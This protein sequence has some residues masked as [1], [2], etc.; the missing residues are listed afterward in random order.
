MEKAPIPTPE[1]DEES[2]KR[3]S[4][5]KKLRK[6]TGVIGI[7]AATLGSAEVD[8]QKVEPY[9][10]KDNEDYKRRQ[11]LYDDSL[12]AY[13]ESQKT[14]EMYNSSS[15]RAAM[16]LNGIKYPEEQINKFINLRN[17]ATNKWM[18]TDDPQI[19]KTYKNI[20]DNYQKV[21]NAIG[22]PYEAGKEKMEKRFI[23]TPTFDN[24]PPEY[25]DSKIYTKNKK[26][27]PEIKFDENAGLNNEAYDYSVPLYKKPVQE[28][29][30]PK[31]E[32][33]LTPDTVFVPSVEPVIHKEEI[34]MPD[35]FI[36][37]NGNKYT[38]EELLKKYPQMKDPR[39]FEKNFHRKSPKE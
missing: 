29:R 9:Y 13:K 26:N 2:P 10:A 1:K 17:E 32:E 12:H 35:Y 11:E 25:H 19:I 5:S 24:L 30:P 20:E 6:L 39:V 8:A 36:M 4:L 15:E 7:S 23:K 14:L 27:E 38:Y 31:K 16:E 33:V 18:H 21:I 34:E 37:P 22:A 3:F 28:V